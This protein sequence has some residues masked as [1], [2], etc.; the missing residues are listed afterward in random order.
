MKQHKLSTIQLD[1]LPIEVLLIVLNY[2]EL[3]DLNRLGQV[4]KRLKSASL[5]DSLWQETILIN[6][7][8]SNNLVEKTLDRG[9]KTLCLKSCRLTEASHLLSTFEDKKL[10]SSQLINLDLYNCD[11]TH[12]F[13][14]T[15]LLSSHSL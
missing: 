12:G 7:T 6:K 1:D 13:L 2:L 10:V 8:M 9:C 5:V 15:L 11:F 4:S 3:P 14:E